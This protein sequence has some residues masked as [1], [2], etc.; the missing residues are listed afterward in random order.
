MLKFA[1]ITDIHVGCA[2]PF[3]GVDRK[4]T[5]YALP[6]IKTFCDNVSDDPQFAFAIQL[7]DLIEDRSETT[8][9]ENY[10]LAANIFAQNLNKTMYHVVGNHDAVNLSS[11]ARGDIVKTDETFY[12]FIQKGYC[13]VV[14][15]TVVP[16][17]AERPIMI[18][19]AQK[20]WLINTLA[21]SDK[22]TI[23][24]CHHPLADQDLSANPGFTR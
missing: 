19:D 18:P 4:L 10:T 15:H 11:A 21:Q 2:D 1:M 3:E 13:F 7:G 24:F 8:D 9:L 20:E 6:M 14:L 12:A 16:Q 23:I 22:P 5:Q 17:Y